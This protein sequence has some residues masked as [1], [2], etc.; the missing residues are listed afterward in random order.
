MRQARQ[1]EFAIFDEL[2]RIISNVI[3]DFFDSFQV[4]SIDTFSYTQ[5]NIGIIMSE[6]S[7]LLVQTFHMFAVIFQRN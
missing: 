4:I 6:T 1:I 2:L 5:Q 3:V 7:D